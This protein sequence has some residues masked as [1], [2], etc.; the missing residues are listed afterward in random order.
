M[1]NI[2]FRL[3]LESNMNKGE[4]VKIKPEHEKSRSLMSGEEGTIVGLNG[5]EVYV[6][7]D[8]SS[9]RDK[10]NQS[11][12]SVEAQNINEVE[13]IGKSV[14]DGYAYRNK[15][16]AEA[17]GSGVTANIGSKGD[18]LYKLTQQ[19]GGFSFTPAG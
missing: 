1:S 7:W 12:W 2:S 19:G 17:S 6:V 18:N 10:N 5:G 13:P 11:G 16:D 9:K 8:K 3:F 15:I 4:R 14:G